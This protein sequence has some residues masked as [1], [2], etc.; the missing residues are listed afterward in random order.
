MVLE[1]FDLK[2]KTA[3][4]TGGARG[5]GRAIAEGFAQAGAYLVIAD[6]D[7][8]AAQ[9]ARAELEERGV[10]AAAV[11]CDVRV[12]AE[13]DELVRAAMERFGRIDVLVNNAG[14]SGA[15][16]PIVR[17]TDEE[18][19]NTLAVNLSGP[20]FCS[21]AAAREMIKQKSGRIINILSMAAH[22]AII[23][24]GDYCAS[25]GGGLM[26]TK[27]LAL[28]LIRHNIRVN[29][30]CPGMFDT[31]MAPALREHIMK[32][33]RQMIPIGRFAHLEEIKG[34]ALFLA[35]PASDYLV[36]SAIPIDGGWSLS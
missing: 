3:V 16:K 35:S 1:S 27:V 13:A 14:I 7:L 15:A 32:N 21:R 10:R 18:W 23:H 4:V 17:L 19:A 29:A 2:D 31:N 34:L 5:I 24:S 26:L 12:A 9:K 30:I 11:R 25:K 22:Q 36:G 6:I 20:F 8:D 28:E 33:I